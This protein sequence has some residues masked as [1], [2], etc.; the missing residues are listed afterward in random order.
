MDDAYIKREPYGV[1]LILGAW[2]YPIQLTLG[3]MVG[4]LA[5]GE[6]VISQFGNVVTIGSPSFWLMAAWKSSLSLL[7]SDYRTAIR[8]PSLKY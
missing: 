2:N 7:R 5:A 3:P 8:P 4:A 6:T 1:A